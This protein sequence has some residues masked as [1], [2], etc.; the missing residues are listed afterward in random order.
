MK[1]IKLFFSLLE[2]R[3]WLEYMATQGF[4]LTDIS[5]GLLYYFKQTDPC[6]KVY[7]IER[8]ALSKNPTVAEL[9]ARSRAIDLATEFGWELVTNDEDMNY[10]FVKDKAGDE[11][12]EF[13]DDKDARL[14]RA[15]RYRRHYSIE[16]P[17]DS[18][19]YCLLIFALYTILFTIGRGWD[20]YGFVLFFLFCTGCMLFISYLSIL[21]GLRFH[22]ELSMSR[23]EWT[24]Y[25]KHTER[26]HFNKVQQLRSYLQEKSESGLSL[27]AFEDG[28][29]TFA[30]DTKRYNYFIDTRSSLKKRLKDEGT[31]YEEERKDWNDVGLKWHETSIAN[32]ARYG[33]KPVALYKKNIL[34]YKRPYSDA[35]LPW[36]NGNDTVSYRPT[37]S[38]VIFCSICGAI[39]AIIGVLLAMNI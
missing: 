36:E 30:E 2:E 5:W 14:E 3:D 32:A 24:L 1:K 11:T 33:L 31:P 19:K 15:E 10:Y 7:E 38:T 37:S 27:I 18:L 39:G 34:I 21:W 8:F 29:F 6:E 35:P 26:K 22:K 13:Y 20:T 25:K 28:Y 23:E 16:L 12:D 4:L 9:T 17:L